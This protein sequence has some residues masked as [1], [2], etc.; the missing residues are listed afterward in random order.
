MFLGNSG[1]PQMK[2]HFAKSRATAEKLLAR[3]QVDEDGAR[4]MN[5]V[6]ENYVELMALVISAT[7]TGRAQSIALRCIEDSLMWANKSITEKYPEVPKPKLDLASGPVPPP[8][9]L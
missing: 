9:S 7:P 3:H 6:R 4:L 5:I 2:E 8:D 1:S